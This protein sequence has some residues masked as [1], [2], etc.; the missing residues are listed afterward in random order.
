MNPSTVAL[1]VPLALSAPLPQEPA[2]RQ[3]D[4]TA[5]DAELRHV[6]DARDVGP[7][8]VGN[9]RAPFPAVS[10]RGIVVPRGGE[11]CAVLEVD[12]ARVRVRSG[13][14]IAFSGDDSLIVETIRAGEV[15]VARESTSERRAIH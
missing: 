3:A 2:P 11:P 10:I 5:L 14:R 15:V 7:R 8:G 13:A 4:P 6:L 1:L 9:A 12:G